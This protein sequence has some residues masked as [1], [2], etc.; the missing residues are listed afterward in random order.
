M[1]LQPY[2]SLP[3]HELQWLIFI[4]ILWFHV[5]NVL[6]R[7]EYVRNITSN[8]KSSHCSLC[9]GRGPQDWRNKIKNINNLSELTIWKKLFILK[10]KLTA[11]NFN[12]LSEKNLISVYIKPTTT[13][14][15]WRPSEDLKSSQEQLMMR[16]SKVVQ[17]FT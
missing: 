15:Y 9:L 11:M 2:G 7:K 17:I 1:L 4:Y 13:K 6:L 10:Y 5:S 12:T 16:S 14:L 3:R 8:R